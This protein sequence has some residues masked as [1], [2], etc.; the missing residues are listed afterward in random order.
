MV[1]VRVRVV[2]SV[3]ALVA[4]FSFG[5]LSGVMAP[6]IMQVPD[7]PPVSE[8]EVCDAYSPQQ[9]LILEELN[10]SK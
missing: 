1:K 4:V 2:I 3:L 6:A 9:H 5:V 10:G 7:A 8:D